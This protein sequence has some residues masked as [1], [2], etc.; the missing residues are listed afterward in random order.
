[1]PMSR[2]HTGVDPLLAAPH[3]PAQPTLSPGLL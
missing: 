1:M 2:H 3:L